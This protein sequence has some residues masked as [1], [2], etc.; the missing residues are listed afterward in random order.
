MR[1][2]AD[3]LAS[4]ILFMGFA[5]IVQ[6]CSDR[7]KADDYNTK[8]Q[9]QGLEVKKVFDLCNKKHKENKALYMKCLDE[10]KLS[11]LLK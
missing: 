4:I 2:F 6:D 5:V 11:E 10:N 9:K 3:V 7:N 8:A 1:E